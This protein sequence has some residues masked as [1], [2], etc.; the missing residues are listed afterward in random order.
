LIEN[1]FWTYP[2]SYSEMAEA[3]PSLY[4][5]L[6]GHTALIFKGDLNY[7]KLIGDIN[8]LPQTPFVESLRGFLPAPLVALRTLKADCIA[9]LRPGLAE[10]ISL[11]NPD[12]L[13]T[14]EFGVIQFASPLS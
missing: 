1:Q 8:W 9:G 12:W 10:E 7:R 2:H 13:V 5:L 4:S 11:S 6:K 3:D 14:G